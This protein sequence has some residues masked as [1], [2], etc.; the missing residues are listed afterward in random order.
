[1]LGVLMSKLLSV[2]LV[3]VHK[4]DQQHCRSEDEVTFRNRPIEDQCCC[5]LPAS[6]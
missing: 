5:A 6:C 3:S 2:V 1:M 4:E